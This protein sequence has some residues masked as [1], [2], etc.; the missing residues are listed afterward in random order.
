MTAAAPLG[1]A[2]VP[3]AAVAIASLEQIRLKPCGDG[4]RAAWTIGSHAQVLYAASPSHFSM[5]AWP[6]V[7]G[8]CASDMLEPIESLDPHAVTASKLLRSSV[9][10]LISEPPDETR[11]HARAMATPLR[12]AGYSVA[13]LRVGCLTTTP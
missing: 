1:H 2:A 4:L 3:V 13:V 9:A 12:G 6:L 5:S 8:V 11:M 10:S 7:G